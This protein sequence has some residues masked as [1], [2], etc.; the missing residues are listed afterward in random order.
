[1]LHQ[2]T[3]LKDPDEIV[4]QALSSKLDCKKLL[5]SSSNIVTFI[6]DLEHL[7][8][9]ILSLKNND[10]NLSQAARDARIK[11]CKNMKEQLRRW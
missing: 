2:V 10:S 6:G 3:C 11:M 4:Q 9:I 7:A 1:M 5:E 8:A